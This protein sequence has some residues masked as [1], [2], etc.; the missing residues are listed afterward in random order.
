MKLAGD[1]ILSLEI[2]FNVPRITGILGH[3]SPGRTA[4]DLIRRSSS[5]GRILPGQIIE[6]VGDVVV[7]DE[8][9]RLRSWVFSTTTSL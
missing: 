8:H 7:I 1:V 3:A 9:G 5:L 6:N 4:R 2:L